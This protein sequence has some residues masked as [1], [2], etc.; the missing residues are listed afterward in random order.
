MNTEISTPN[1][2]MFSERKLS[3]PWQ[4]LTQF[5]RTQPMWVSIIFPVLLTVLMGWIDDITGWEVSLFIF[6]AIPIFQAVW[7]ANVQAGIIITVISSIVWWYANLDSQPY[8]TL[9]GYFWALM[10]RQFYFLV[11]VFAVSVVRKKQD[12][13][14]AYIRMLE[15][16]QQME[17]DIV[18]VSEYEQQRIGR[19][20]H[21]GLCQ[22]L[23]AIGC[24]ARALTE[25]LQSKGIENADDASAIEECLQQAV[26][27]ARD[28]ARGI[29][30][31]HV[32]RSGLATALK[33]LAVTTSRLT[34]IKITVQDTEEVQLSSPE[35]SMHLYRIAQEAVANAVRHASPHHVWIKIERLKGRLHLTVEDDGRG[36]D[37]RVL[38]KSD[39]M[40]LRTMRYRAQSIGASLEI[41][42][43][44]EGG[45]RICCRLSTE[46]E[47]T[48]NHA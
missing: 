17:K 27:E 36:I 4:D 31:V 39:G 12:A 32:D 3:S 29:F 48:S 46:T 25:D 34:G 5:M 6:Y 26:V 30:P 16:R 22:Q 47:T 20:L 37:L 10:N 8:A 14:A 28:M 45:N 13:D 11:V 21:D 38:K 15:E 9:L 18:A 40:G 42:P 2:P 41:E 44:P 33:D 19:D 43:R 35:I 7:W 24:A 1:L 23:A